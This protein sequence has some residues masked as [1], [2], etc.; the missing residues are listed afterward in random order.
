[1]QVG[2]LDLLGELVV[3]R[4]ERDQQGAAAAEPDVLPVDAAADGGGAGVGGGDD[5]AVGGRVLG[6][7][8]ARRTSCCSTGSPGSPAL[9]RSR[10]AI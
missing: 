6:E 5:A 7:T 8:G 10:T 3:Q 1:V 2:A 4:V 9:I